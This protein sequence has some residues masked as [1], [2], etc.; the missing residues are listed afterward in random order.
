MYHYP[1]W[2]RLWHWLNAIFFIVLLIT[3]ISMQ[4][5]NPERA[6][7][8]PFEKA[9]EFHNLAGVLLSINYIFFVFGNLF[10]TN[11]K[12][13]RMPRKGFFKRLMEQSQFYLFGMFQ[14]KNPPFPLSQE[15]KFNPLQKIIYHLTMYWGFPIIII[16]GLSLFFPEIIIP[17]LFGVSGIFLTALLHVIVGFFLSLFLFIHIYVCTIGVNIAANFKS[18]I[19]GWH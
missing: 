7:M 1:V 18:M 3:G 4:Y 5:S 11:G 13:Y 15:E 14:K 19:T 8:V 17:K 10:T 16:T 2:V 9:V 12:Y 6:L